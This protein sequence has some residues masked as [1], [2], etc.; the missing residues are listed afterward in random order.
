[1]QITYEDVTT[2]GET[3]FIRETVM[4][5]RTYR[6][7]IQVTPETGAVVKLYLDGELVQT[8]PITY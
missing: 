5:S 2:D 8:I 4:E 1:V 7:P 6:V 3:V